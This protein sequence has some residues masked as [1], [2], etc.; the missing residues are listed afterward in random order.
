MDDFTL[1]IEAERSALNAVLANVA[2]EFNVIYISRPK[3]G[4][5]P[6][7]FSVTMTAKVCARHKEFLKPKPCKRTR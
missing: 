6:R 7:L 4:K 2:N 5:N 3:P 1:T